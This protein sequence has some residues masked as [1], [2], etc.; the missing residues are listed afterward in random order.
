MGQLKA[1][2]KLRFKCLSRDE[3]KALEQAQNVEIETL[4][5]AQRKAVLSK[6]VFTP[7][8]AKIP[9]SER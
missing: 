7:I 9:E 2:D 8:L 6:D 1:G 3:A 4:T 5:P